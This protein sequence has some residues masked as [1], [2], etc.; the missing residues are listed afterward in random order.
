MRGLQSK[1][2]KEAGGDFKKA[3]A[4]Q[5]A[6]TGK[7]QHH[8]PAPEKKHAHAHHAEPHTFR[9][10]VVPTRDGGAITS[11]N[12]GGLSARITAHTMVEYDEEQLGMILRGFISGMREPVGPDLSSMFPPPESEVDSRTWREGAQERELGREVFKRMGKALLYFKVPREE[13]SWAYEIALRQVFP[14]GTIPSSTPGTPEA[15][16]R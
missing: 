1:F 7:K 6:A 3:W 9:E 12:M 15:R 10:T 11:R 2:V 13:W 16:R 5:R 8:H 14:M 4:L